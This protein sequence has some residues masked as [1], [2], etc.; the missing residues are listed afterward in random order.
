MLAMEGASKSINNYLVGS[1][2]LQF[3]LVFSLIKFLHLF[4]SKDQWG[5]DLF[6]T[7]P[8]VTAEMDPSTNLVAFM[9]PP[10]TAM[11]LNF[12]ALQLFVES[13]VFS[14]LS[15][16]WAHITYL[17][18][19]PWSFINAKRKTP[20][21][22]DEFLIRG[23]CWFII[24]GALSPHVQTDVEGRSQNLRDIIWQQCCRENAEGTSVR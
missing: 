8:L 7:V 15:I 5:K 13:Q 20:T 11:W 1:S 19:F 17:T 24:T 3:C 14:E 22:L 4:S 16:R 12:Q 6:E 23:K 10:H 2:G 21:N 9:L 18:S